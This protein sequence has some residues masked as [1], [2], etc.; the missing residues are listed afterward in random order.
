MF[1]LSQAQIQVTIFFQGIYRTANAT[2]TF[3]YVVVY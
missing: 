1:Q 3:T 2:P